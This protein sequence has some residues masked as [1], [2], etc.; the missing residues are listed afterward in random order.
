MPR[1]VLPEL[2]G[3]GALDLT[4]AAAATTATPDGA[5]DPVESLAA[6]PPADAAAARR[7]GSVSRLQR[8]PSWN[9]GRS[10]S[11]AADVPRRPKTVPAESC[12]SLSTTVC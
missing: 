3:I 5:T 1:V 9:A 10:E 7:S 6:T 8:S 12:R 4:A 2:T 11:D